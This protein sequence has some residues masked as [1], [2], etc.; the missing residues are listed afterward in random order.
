MENINHRIPPHNIE[1]ERVT[2]SAV[3]SG[4]GQAHEVYAAVAPA[5]YYRQAHKLIFQA[6]VDLQSKSQPVDV[7]SVVN[8]LKDRGKLDETGGP[9]YICGLTDEIPINAGHH[10]AIVR[11]KARLRRL[12]SEAQAI[13]AM[14]YESADPGETL[15]DAA[16]RIM[17]VTQTGESRDAELLSVLA[18]RTMEETERRSHNPS[19]P[20][21]PTGFID[22]DRYIGGLEPSDLVL[23]AARPSM[24]KTSFA[25]NMVQ[26][27]AVDMGIPAQVFSLE[28]SKEQLTQRMV[29]SMSGVKSQAIRDGRIAENEWPKLAKAVGRALA[30]NVMIDDAAGLT[31]MELRARALRTALKMGG[32]G[33]IVVDYLQLMRGSV[34][35][36]SRE[37]EISE[38]SGGLKN[39]AKELK[40]PVVALSQLNRSLESR[41]NKRP[42]LADLRDSGSLEQ[43]ADI[44]GFI[45]RD[46]VYNTAPD[47]PNKGIAE[48]ILGKQ[49]RGPIGTAKLAWV[50]ATTTF[51]DL[52]WER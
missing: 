33:L 19:S 41:P 45:Y 25:M 40:V 13:T 42:V 32:V 35:N 36:Q 6:A 44:V 3:L 37:R 1:A 34:R 5:D 18:K 24:G 7:V 8:L 51:E 14:C 10:A 31:V 38:I 27:V 26:R 46:E 23:I 28:M 39:L 4:T 21:I 43:D 17:A 49:R 48:F 20:G 50:G 11:D 9:G 12:I 16:G 30:S 2:L 15:N 29:S 47:N 52:A 22:I